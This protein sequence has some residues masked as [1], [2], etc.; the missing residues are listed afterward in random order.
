[1]TKKISIE[2]AR[3]RAHTARYTDPVVPC[4][5]CKHLTS[6]GSQF[7]DAGWTCAAY[8]D[9]ILYGILTRRNPHTDTT[10]SLTGAMVVFDPVIYTDEHTG[11]Q[12]HYLADGDWRYVDGQGEEEDEKKY[13]EDRPWTYLTGGGD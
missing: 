1:M 3:R 2:E 8:P 13:T 5:H 7:S 11:R 10:I 4:M 9:Q 12:W 6:V